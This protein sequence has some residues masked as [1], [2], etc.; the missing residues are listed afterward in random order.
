MKS[1]TDK[2]AS[3][4]SID[5]MHAAPPLTPSLPARGPARDYP[6]PEKLDRPAAT[7]SHRSARRAASHHQL[8]E[9]AGRAWR[10]RPGSRPENGVGKCL[11]L[12]LDLKEACSFVF[13]RILTVHCMSNQATIPPRTLTPLSSTS[14]KS[15]EKLMPDFAN[16]SASS[17]FTESQTLRVAIS[18]PGSGV[19][20][21]H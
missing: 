12:N 1:K 14:E 13:I 2:R 17:R 4:E 9:T 7:S 5:E 16:F 21:N 8:R 10:R 3:S 18:Y 6:W 11:R 19:H 15:S 20:V